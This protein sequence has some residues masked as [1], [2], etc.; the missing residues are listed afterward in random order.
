MI[1]YQPEIKDRKVQPA[2][3]MGTRNPSLLTTFFLPFMLDIF[4]AKDYG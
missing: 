3:S 1:S 2:K 4:I